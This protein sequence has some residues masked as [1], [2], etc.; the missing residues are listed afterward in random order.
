MSATVTSTKTL[1]VAYI[2]EAPYPTF[3]VNEVLALRRRGVEVTVLNSYRPF[4]QQDPAAETMRRES[5]YFAS[6]YRR[7]LWANLYMAVLRPLAY[8]WV[9]VAMLRHRLL[10]HLLPLS[11]EYAYLLKQRR[12]AHV[13]GMYGTTPATLAL[14]V[15][16]LAGLPFSFTCH[17]Y[18]ILL[19]NPLLTW[20]ARHARFLTTISE[21]NRRH[22]HETFPR[23]A[24]D[25]VH[26][27]YLGVDVE[28]WHT[29]VEET[30]PPLILSVASLIPCKGHLCLVRALGLLREKGIDYKALFVGEGELRPAIETEI[31]RLDLKERIRLVGA[32][33]NGQVAEMVSRAS[34][35]VLPAIVDEQNNH[36]GVP[37]ALMEAMAA[38]KAVVSTFVSGI[39]ELIEADRSGVLVPEKDVDALAGAL[40]RLL[41][42][43]SLRGMLGHAASDHIA[44]SFTLERN[45]AQM[46]ALFWSISKG[47]L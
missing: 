6:G 24:H 44:R 45:A 47:D 38:G 16:R 25:K 37:V 19:P 1:R 3:A 13:H 4:E 27:V 36:D 41:Q 22:I 10:W 46:E 26:V 21:F 29:K 30:N 15:A 12:V 33:P 7:T 31:D 35:F 14:L 42:D 17:S 32:L 28:L 5:F 34:I 8:F 23:I 43:V 20:K 18:E 9:I 40:E 39:P 2:L 11:A